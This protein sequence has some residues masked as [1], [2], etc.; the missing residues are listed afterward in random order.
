M[1]IAFEMMFVGAV[2]IMFVGLLQHDPRVN[3]GVSLA[4]CLPLD[5]QNHPIRAQVDSSV[6]LCLLDTLGRQSQCLRG[7]SAP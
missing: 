2:V 4:V 3:F 5:P 6:Q 1:M 7:L